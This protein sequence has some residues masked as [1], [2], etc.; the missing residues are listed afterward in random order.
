MMIAKTKYILVLLIL[1]LV[2]I[3][4]IIT[5]QTEPDDF[6]LGH[7]FTSGQTVITNNGTFYDAGGFANYGQ[8]EDWTVTFCSE[9]GNP[10]TLDF[11]G[12]ATHYGGTL[13]PPGGAYADYDYMNI[14]YP[15]ASY[16]A[17]NDDTPE[18]S[19]T[20]ASGCI[21]F[22][23]RS[24]SDSPMENGWEAEISA[25]P[26]PAN[27]DPCTAEELIVGSSCT[28]TFYNN[29]GA[30]NTTGLGSPS[31]HTYFGGDVWFSA[32][33]PAS[34]QLK[35]ETF[36]GTLDWAVMVLY[37]GPNCSSLSELSCDETSLAMPT[38]IVTR[39]PGS[40]IWVRIFGDQ[41][42]SGTFGICASDPTSQITGSTGPA[43][44]GDETTND[45]WL[46]AD[47]GVLDGTDNPATSGDDVKTWNDQSGNDNHLAQTTPSQ[48]PE[49]QTN[50]LNNQPII[51][52]DGVDEYMNAELS[53]LS[54]P[55]SFITVTQFSSSKDAYVLTLGDLNSTQT[56]SISRE[57]D[58]RYY[59]FTGAKRYGPDLDN[60][61]PY[62]IHAAHDIASPYHNLHLD[63]SACTVA[64]YG[65][66]L[67]TDGSLILGAS[68][69]IDTWLHGD[70]AEV[71]LYN[72]LLN[73]A[74]KIIVENSIAAKYGI[75]LSQ[76]DIYS[77]ESTH[78]YDV[79]G[80]GRVDADNM[81][82]HAQSARTL[83]IGGA[84]DLENNEFLL[85]GHDNGDM[86][87]WTSI[88]QPNGDNRIQR[89]VR[90]WIVDISGG[91]GMGPFTLSL[92]DSL[93]PA[94]PAGFISFNLWIDADGDF[95]AGAVAY[96]VVLA[97]DEYIA[98]NIPLNDGDYITVG[99]VQ[100][101]VQFTAASSSG[102]E[103]VT[104]PTIEV[105]L[106]YAVSNEVSVQYSVYEGT[107]TAGT[108]YSL[109]DNQLII[110]PGSKT[111]DII[112]LIYD[113]TIA[114]I[115]DEYIRIRI[116]D[117]SSGLLVSSDTVHTYTIVNDDIEIDAST[118]TDTISNCLASSANFSV[119]VTGTGPYTYSWTPTDSLSDP[120]ISNPV[121]TPSTTTW[122]FVTVTDQTTLAEATDSVLITVIPAPSKPTAT[123]DDV[124][125]FCQGDS[126]TLTS[127]AGIT[128]LWSSGETTQSIVV[129]TS[130]N[131]SVTIYD[132]YGCE[133][134]VS[135]PVVVTVNALPAKPTVSPDGTVEVCNGDSIE[136]TSSA[137]DSYSWST[138][139][140]S[141]SIWV[142]AAGDYFVSVTNTNGCVS[143][144][145]DTT[146]VMINALPTK[147][148]ITPDGPTTFCL[149]D[150]VELTS[151]PGTTYIWSN[152][153]TD[154]KVMIKTSGDY[155]VQVTDANGCT[156]P[157][158]DTV[159]VLV[160]P[161]PAKPTITPDGPTTFCDGDSVKLTS[162]AGMTYLWSTSAT[163]QEITVTT[164]GNYSVVITDANGCVSPESDQTSVT[165]N[166]LPGKPGV[167]PDGATSFCDGDSVKL[168]S[169]PA[170]SWLWSNGETTQTI[171][172]MV[173]DDFA[174]Q[175]TDGNGCTSP[176]SDTVSTVVFALPAKPV[177]TASD[178][179]AFCDG[180]SIQ[181][182]A[183]SATTWHW[184]TGE[185]TQTIWVSTAGNF[186]I[187][188]TDANGCASDSS[189]ALMTNIY[190]TP[191]APTITP[192][193]STTFCAGDSITLTSSAGS[194]FLW[195]NSA[196][197][198][199]I[200]VMAGGDYS[201][202]ITDVNGCVSPESAQTTVTVNPLP[203]KPGVTPDGATSFCD[204]D[205]VKLTS[206]PATSWL[207]S[208]GETT[209]TITVKVADDFAIQ[210][211]DGNGCTSPASDTVSTVVFALPAKPVITAS[212]D[213]AFCDG[214]SIQLD[215]GSATTWHWS[216][217]E[218][219]Q[220]IW[221]S[222]A[223]NFKVL[224]TDANGCASDSSDALMTNIYATPLAPTITPTGSTTF[225]SGDSV[226]LSSSPGTTY[227]WSNGATDPDVYITIG[228]DY[229]V[230]VTDGNGCESPES[231]QTTVTV[232]SLPGQPNITPDGATSFCD[233]DSV[234][235]TSDTGSSWL[236]S[237]GDTTQTITVTTADNFSVKIT[238]AN[239]CTSPSS[240]IISTVLFTLPS[241][242]VIT[243]GDT[244]FCEGDSLQLDA[245]SAS[246]WNWSTGET[247]Q[248]IWVSTAGNFKVLITDANGCTSDSSDAL[249][250]TIVPAPPAPTITVTGDS[251]FCEGGSAMLT[252]SAGT[253][254]LWSTGETTQSIT[255]T[256]EDSYSVA[257]TGNNGCTSQPSAE[258]IITVYDLPAQPQISGDT[259]YCED[260][261]VTLNGP[262]ASRYLW[263]NGDTTQEI[264]VLAG[265]YT[266]TITDAN[267]CVSMASEVHQVSESAR[268]AR[269]VI[270]G[271]DQYCEGNTTTLSA[272]ISDQY[273]WSNGEIT[274]SVIVTAGTYYVKV[275]DAAGCESFHS[276]TIE[277]SE[278]PRPDKPLITPDGPLTFW[279]GDSVVLVSSAATG[280][281]WSPGAETS[282]QITVKV[283]G[284]YSVVVTDDNGCES[285][286]SDAVLVTVDALDK[287]VVTADGA[288]SFCAGGSVQLSTDPA[289][290]YLWSSG[291][292]TQSIMITTSGDYSL[293]IFDE[294]GHESEESDIITVTVFPVPAIAYTSEDV[295]CHGQAEGS[296]SIIVSGGTA[297]FSYNWSNDNTNTTAEATGLAAGSLSVMVTD[298][299]GCNADTDIV[300]TE[301][302]ALLLEL[303]VTQPDCPDSYNGAIT[304]VVS[305]GVQ[306]YDYSWNTGENTSDLGDLGAG[307]FSLTITDANNC[308]EDDE[309]ALNPLQ[310][311]CLFIPDIITPNDDG[312][313]DVWEIPGL[314]YYPGA[315][316][317]IYN[318]WGK[319]IFY[320][321]GYEI[322]FDGT[323]DGS[324]LPMD[325]YHY[326][327]DIKNGLKPFVG[328]IT[329][330]R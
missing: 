183:G 325:S 145:S 232:N 322:K 279:K 280:Y 214:D 263:S 239:G 17:Y 192:S 133:S 211:T 144:N 7:G 159:T 92:N 238:D 272:T 4:V 254:Y 281:L 1:A 300:I 158:S 90:E 147:P 152:G 177:I 33:V 121:A 71:I 215:A 103:S 246:T 265:N 244:A 69:N 216:T 270:S 324:D 30:Y 282:A 248:T 96:P 241:T 185:T 303:A 225:C 128:Y 175:V 59:S 5:A 110:S 220:T 63:D 48:Q 142:K 151:S 141:Q 311:L 56:A 105:S 224:I 316:V 146:T 217:G 46:R 28:P 106:N 261:T 178:D 179:T 39:P 118:D 122:Y 262:A 184:S 287:P 148:T 223:G 154:Q 75:S 259:V 138:G 288:L 36:A 240:D 66:F 278:L 162:S 252:S 321:E 328:N 84:A 27:N 87:A 31:C 186:K 236:W 235:L 226:L 104:N 47:Q 307:T 137:E 277:V 256:T 203:G 80:I 210:V 228:G 293:I 229:S 200:T 315:V 160:N 40:T 190:A 100:P 174:V 308:I 234:K 207:W 136:L 309:V 132:E 6:Y 18:F 140:T 193:G 102:Y 120:A 180:D 9:N 231:A 112:P 26:P 191:P 57:S 266:L 297:P 312:F 16:V 161:L 64:D 124:T 327:I 247:T 194:S 20:S 319:R 131:Y 50:I 115:P 60:N 32:V 255:V 123:P 275:T 267:G 127:S 130:G 294:S 62:I 227:L 314:Q 218:T 318:R 13:P 164:A 305:G 295:L 85:F 43:G 289:T 168:T 313:N 44:V 97:G 129:K 116:Y 181:L 273:L 53:S 157:A 242:P 25:I 204:G 65:S 330:V 199:A 290:G 8:G 19:F 317:E 323:F 52:F 292:S 285:V 11:D 283:S 78:S 55:V 268:P 310:E 134:P 149:G 81:H 111:A 205:S 83:S 15:G 99:I 109:A 269:P 301:P 67:V 79:A 189:D 21:T 286:A 187:L 126:V 88:E 113:D 260:G 114:E 221:V 230:V 206:D 250:T 284:S 195:S 77:Y 45:L 49:Y 10:I 14:D 169:D 212:D 276:D 245:G 201:V 12:F 107:A 58:D 95:S 101:V 68:R 299:N 24:E 188:I 329:I 98:N 108:D 258:Q 73:E 150:S 41:A 233:G 82:T 34:G 89:I 167:T 326:I 196:T 253:T 222:T 117:P 38:R 70:L 143:P 93:M 202:V 153:G 296:V 271:S 274:Q 72:Q 91:D 94:F 198:P 172:V 51:R 298:N 23:F 61:V 320:S 125:T 35:I 209:Q 156:S 302:D 243:S 176:A 119:A 54:S 257:I 291:D 76:T 197:D 173:A 208:N 2:Y 86:T 135:D 155:S 213:T 249:I 42:K 306:P 237:N 182:D 29:K 219:T 165:I 163:D 22:R 139:A 3:P 171:T 170:T 304:T 166:S 37:S 251:E 264:S 74:Q